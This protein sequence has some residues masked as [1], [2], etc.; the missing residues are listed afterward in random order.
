MCEIIGSWRNPNHQNG[1]KRV[2]TDLRVKVLV[3]T[4]TDRKYHQATSTKL[5]ILLPLL[6]SSL[7][8]NQHPSPGPP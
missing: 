1:L 3:S 2:L 4:S 8:A 7:V 5:F 6:P